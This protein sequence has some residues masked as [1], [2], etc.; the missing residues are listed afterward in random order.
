MNKFWVV[1]F[2]TFI[3]NAKTKSFIIS[4]IATALL[5]G[6][7]FNIPN[8]IR[9]FDQEKIEY[10]GVI[11][12]NGEIFRALEAYLL[13]SSSPSKNELQ[14]LAFQDE[15]QAKKQVEEQEIVGYVVVNSDA[16]GNLDATYKALKVN[17]SLLASRLEQGLNHVQ[18]QGKASQL[19]LT[20]EEA[21]QLFQTI[22]LE[23]EALSE[24][25]KTEEEIV[26][27]KVL[28]YLL[29]F[30]IYFSVLM[31][32]NL[33]ALEVIKEKSS[34]VMEILISS[35][36]P[37]TQMF[38]KI[39][40]VALLGM[41]QMLIFIAVG[42]I[43]LQFGDKSVELGEMKVDFAEIPVSTV[44]Y[45]V[46]F[47]ILGYLLY[48]TI[49]AMLGSLVS[50]MEEMNGIL[51]PLTLVIV[52]GFMIAM[53]GLSKPEASFIVVTSFI[54]FFTPMIMF[55]RVGV[56]DPALWEVLLSI[57]LLVATIMAMGWLASKVYRGGVL[58]Y[59][60]SASI[61]DIGKAISLHRDSER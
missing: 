53:F 33:V 26:Q 39:L 41:V 46:I 50:R 57:F 11:D 20:E 34:R 12:Q 15:E 38:G 8:M 52:A 1:L 59:G 16:E 61:K 30:A 9:F 31:F 17:D 27:S 35:V 55:L 7:V 58:L 42:F 32:G 36:H 60:K 5:V 49:A 22:K 23:K 4:T 45:A 37:V 25:A 2:H 29:L 47:F 56:S 28:V 3:T 14:L 54:P 43:S 40:G 19:H 48:A 51:T 6:V 18:F 10:V 44:I 13:S 24:T 21:L